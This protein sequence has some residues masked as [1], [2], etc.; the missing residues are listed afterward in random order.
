MYQ[1][2]KTLRNLRGFCEYSGAGDWLPAKHAVFLADSIQARIESVASGDPKN[3]LVIEAPPRHGK[4]ELVS[5][6][7]PAWYLT[8]W[9]KRNV[10]LSSYSAEFSRV[11]GR[12]ARSIV[13][14]IS[15]KTGIEVSS[16]QS[17]ASDWEIAG[18]GG[19]M[20][21]SGIGGSLTG[22]GASLLIIDDPVKNAEEAE[23]ATV[24]DSHWDW[25]QTT[26]STRIEPGGIAVIMATRWHRDDLIGRILKEQPDQVYRLRLPALA[27]D[28]DPLGRQPG[29]A[30][31]PERWPQAALKRK[32]V[33][34]AR[35]WWEALYQQNPIA[36]GE[37]EFPSAWFDDRWFEEWPKNYVLRTMSL[38]P[39]KGKDAKRSDYQALVKLCIGNDDV[40]YVQADM[41]KQPIPQMI[42]DAVDQY[43]QFRPQAF[44]L[45]A[46][47]WQ[48]LLAPDFQE[49]FKR[50]GILAPEVWQ[51]NNQVNK[52]VRIRRISGYLSQ[53][54]IRFK[55]NCP[56]TKIL[57][58]QMIDFPSGDHDDGPDSLEMAI[59]L[60]EQLTSGGT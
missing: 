19:S 33:A 6:R 13:Q 40:L 15:K 28:H 42:A 35:A 17:A 16:T 57:I 24:R 37:T 48:D 21:T 27:D 3:L 39:S 29:E 1:L 51:I 10:L 5:K 20:T 50:Q 54:R 22:R 59:R 2:A 32:Q 52:L 31:W 43:N 4:S 30:L 41:K 23:S 47:A 36:S 56:G 7:L 49:E 46:N 9:P 55:Q 14:A 58:E 53:G 18:Y 25:W 45:E 60:A 11:W 34:M 8:R 12:R 44:G 38:D 26:A